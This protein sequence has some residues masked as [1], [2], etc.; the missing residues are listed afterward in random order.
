MGRGFGCYSLA[1]TERTEASLLWQ[2]A[3]IEDQ[4]HEKGPKFSHFAKRPK[5]VVPS[6]PFIIV[7]TK[8]V[9]HQSGLCG[10][11]SGQ[12]VLDAGRVSVDDFLTRWVTGRVR[13]DIIYV[14]IRLQPDTNPT[15]RHELTPLVSTTHFWN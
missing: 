10:S 7:P 9:I 8:D 3:M 13:V 11:G 5:K 12:P 2:T 4:L 14:Y 15:R 6:G 1:E